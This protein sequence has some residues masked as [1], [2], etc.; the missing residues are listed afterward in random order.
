MVLQAS[1]DLAEFEPKTDDLALIMYT[2]GSTGTP[3]GVEL[4]H[5][6]FISVVARPFLAQPLFLSLPSVSCPGLSDCNQ[7][8]FPF[9][10]LERLRCLCVAPLPST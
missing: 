8:P 5:K 9:P 3:K 10:A 2:S 6:N 1:F 4:T 7:P